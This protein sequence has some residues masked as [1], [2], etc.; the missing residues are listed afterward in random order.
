LL[1]HLMKDYYENE[2][3]SIQVKAV[4]TLLY[5]YGVSVKMKYGNFS[6]ALDGSEW[7]LFTSKKFLIE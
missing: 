2:Y 5:H 6:S 7:N 4:A 1:R 3:D